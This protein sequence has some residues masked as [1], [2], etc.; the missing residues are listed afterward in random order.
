M[1]WTVDDLPE[2]QRQQPGPR[3]TE[4]A[5]QERVVSLARSLGWLVYHSYDSRR[6]Q[7]GFPDLVLVRADRLI[8]AELK[9][10]KGQLTQAQEEW[11]LALAVTRAEI[12]LWRPRHWDVI[13]EVLK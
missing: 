3:L 7:P 13:I 6:S 1:I 9:Q 2:G 5:F 11:L 12:H 4:R 8:F 10:C